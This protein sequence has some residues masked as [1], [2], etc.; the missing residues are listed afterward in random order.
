MFSAFVLAFFLHIFGTIG[1]FAFIPRSMAVVMPA[2]GLMGPR[3]RDLSLEQI[4]H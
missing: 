1:V 4:Y 3:T 2:I